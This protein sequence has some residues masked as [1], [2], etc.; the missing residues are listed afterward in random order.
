[1]L[2][3]IAQEALGSNLACYVSL[4]RTMA[5]GL[6]ICLGCAVK[7]ARNEHTEYYYACKDGPVFAAEMIDWEAM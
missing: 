4:E 1:M 3:K 7:A 5:C 6:G 2:K